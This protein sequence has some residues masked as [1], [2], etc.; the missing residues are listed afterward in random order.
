M[1]TLSYA[2][3]GCGRIAK[4]HA[5]ALTKQVP[6]ARMVAVCD[7]DE[8][9]ATQFSKDYNVPGFTS[10]ADMMTAMKEHI[11]VINILTPTGY[12]A[13]NIIEVADYG[14]HVVVE[15]PM[16][17]TVED[18][19]YAIEYCKQKNVSLSVV[20]Q[21]RYN[22]P[23]QALYNTLKA[24]RFGN[25]SMV[26]ARVCWSRNQSY[27]DQAAWRGTWLLDGGV[28]SNQASHHIDLLCWLFGK[29]DSLF[30]YTATHL[31]NIESEDTGVGVFKFNKGTLGTI[32]AT[33]ATRPKDLEASI[34]VIGELGTVEIGG[35][36]VNEI[37]RWEFKHPIESD[38]EMLTAHN[39]N[40]PNIYGFGHA[41][42]LTEL[43]QAILNNQPPPV[44][45]ASGL[46][47]LKII[48]ALYESAASG[49]EIKL[50]TFVQNHSKLGKRMS[51]EQMENAS[52]I[53]LTELEQPES[54][55]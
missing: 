50:D 4:K 44:D 45:G 9:K 46:E 55:I 14:C 19:Q 36:A 41:A 6:N 52:F 5:E 12:H 26:G 29:V 39:E 38:Q 37:K 7:I 1:N 18:A 22:L 47:S 51:P 33:T 40:P 42:Y 49:K 28:F 13:K 34:L 25:I 2:L 54:I 24:G 27:Y 48:S 23:I 21:N 17:L 15:K 20:K 43:T 35:F 30:S 10:L 8:K 31:V 11:D 16:A 32:E 3:L 53:D